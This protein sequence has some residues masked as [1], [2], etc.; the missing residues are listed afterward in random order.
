MNIE[1]NRVQRRENIHRKARYAPKKLGHPLG[2][3]KYH[4]IHKAKEDEEAAIQ[5]KRAVS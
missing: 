4:R 1:Q 2:M 5:K 3:S